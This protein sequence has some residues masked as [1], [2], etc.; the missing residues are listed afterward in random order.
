MWLHQKMKLGN[1]VSRFA[2]V[3][4]I[5]YSEPVRRWEKIKVNFILRS[6]SEKTRSECLK[7]DISEFFIN[8]VGTDNNLRC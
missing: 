1:L 3:T 6:K 8:N 4:I 2:V 7:T 5:N